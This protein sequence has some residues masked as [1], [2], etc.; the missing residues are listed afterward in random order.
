MQNSKVFLTGIT[1][2]CFTFYHFPEAIW[3]SI[4]TT[5]IIERSNKGLKHKSKAKEQ[6]PNEDALERFVCCYYSELNRSY[7]DRVQCGFQQASAEILQIFDKRQQDAL[8]GTASGDRVKSPMS[9]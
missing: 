8:P 1:G 4:Y 6:F 3:K 2:A 7:A 9:A 5:N